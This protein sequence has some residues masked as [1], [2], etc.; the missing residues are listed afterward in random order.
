MT[1]HHGHNYADSH[2]KDMSGDVGD[3]ENNPSELCLTHTWLFVAW[4]VSDVLNCIDTECAVGLQL[5]ENWQSCRRPSVTIG[6]NNI[7]FWNDYFVD[8][9]R[10]M[11]VY[12]ER[13]SEGYQLPEAEHE[14]EPVEELVSLRN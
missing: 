13:D 10:V 5:T 12:Q 6:A 7:N 1:N 2:K 11:A 14:P 3:I 4:I 9:D 8:I